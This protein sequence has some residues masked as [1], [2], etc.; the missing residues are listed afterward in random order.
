MYN[1]SYKRQDGKPSVNSR[2][3]RKFHAEEDINEKTLRFI[4]LIIAVIII[5]AVYLINSKTNTQQFPVAQLLIDTDIFPI[6][7]KEI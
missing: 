5:S 3:R 7:D 1:L 6:V 2:H 4:V